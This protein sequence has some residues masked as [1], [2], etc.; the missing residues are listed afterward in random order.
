MLSDSL[1]YFFQAPRTEA[2]FENFQQLGNPKVRT[3]SK[4]HP[5][6]LK[7]RKLLVGALKL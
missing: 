4:N 7:G 6:L 2:S 1:I 5:T 3:K